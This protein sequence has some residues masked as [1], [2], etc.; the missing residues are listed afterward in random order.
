MKKRAKPCLI[1]LIVF[2]L[3]IPGCRQDYVVRDVGGTP[4]VFAPDSPAPRAAWQT[5]LTVRIAGAAIAGSRGAAETLTFTPT[6][7]AGASLPIEI[8][9]KA[10]TDFLDVLSAKVIVDVTSTDLPRALHL[11]GHNRNRLRAGI[12]QYCMAENKLIRPGSAERVTDAICHAL[13]AAPATFDETLYQAYG[14]D[15]EKRCIE[16]VPGMILRVDHAPYSRIS[17]EI[18]R[19]AGSGSSRFSIISVPAPAA[20]SATQPGAPT[21]QP[22]RVLAFDALLARMPPNVLRDPPQPP[23][24]SATGLLDLGQSGYAKPY[25]RVF[26]PDNVKEPTAVPLLDATMSITLVGADNAGDLDALSAERSFLQD[27]LSERSDLASHIFVGRAAVVLEIEVQVNGEPVLAPVGTTVRNLCERVGAIRRGPLSPAH[28]LRHL[29]VNRL[30]D[31]GARCRVRFENP[32][33]RSF[34]LP[35]MQGDEIQWR[36]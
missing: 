13:D 16:L 20:P 5:R 9:L 14:L 23:P 7:Q 29:S 34:D 8:T 10:P 22:S 21:T 11:S 30:D 36:N 28:F 35:V 27:K 33:E 17:G 12:L 32:T 26:Y 2:L 31:S 18:S 24:W 15:P 19:H 3:F 1:A 4:L 25:W 6:I